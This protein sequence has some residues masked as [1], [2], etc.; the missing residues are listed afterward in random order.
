[1]KKA[2]TLFLLLAIL[3]TKIYAQ[4]SIS[5]DGR[6]N[7]GFEN[8]VFNSPELYLDRAGTLFQKSDLVESDGFTEFGWKFKYRSILKKKHK[9]SIQNTGS[10][11][12]F[13]SLANA[14]QRGTDLKGKY[15]YK[16]SR[17]L[18]FGYKIDLTRS[19]KL[20]TNILGDELTATFTFTQVINQGYV[21][22]RIIEN[23]K[24]KLG[25][26][27]K[28]RRYKSNP[29]T[30]SLSYNT[31][32]LVFSTE[33]SFNINQTKTRLK[34]GVSSAGRKYL[35]RTAKD[36][37]GN[38]QVGYPTRDWSYFVTELSYRLKFR[39]NLEFEPYIVYTKRTDNFQDQF[40]YKE[41]K[42]GLKFSYSLDNALIEFKTIN[43]NKNYNIRPAL[44]TDGAEIPLRYKYFKMSLKGEYRLPK[45]ITLF[46]AVNYE[47]RDSN[48]TSIER[49]PRREYDTYEI[50]TG[51]QYSF[52]KSLK[53][54]KYP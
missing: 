42:T 16:K 52:Q 38:G 15:I 11:K 41:F 8:N 10:F 2:Y 1:M 30:E 9:I 31:P 13:F 20:V 47:S 40:S 36:A 44:Q 14:N 45:R 12:N 27:Y 34:L 4:S 32:A 54:R 21:Q 17:R 23:N 53:S 28:I 5:A 50:Y 48:V 6:L 3:S 19:K 24:T 35:D 26:Y 49:R 25:A 37:N 7:I 29:N 43:Y 33:Q 46:F 18:Q 51:I 22:Y 39:N